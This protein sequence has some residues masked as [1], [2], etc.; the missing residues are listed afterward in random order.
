MDASD[1]QVNRDAA[2]VY[3]EFFVPAL[4]APWAPK[5]ADALKPISNGFMLDVACGTGVLGRELARRVGPARVSGVDC[6]EGMLAVARRM[7]PDVGWRVARAEALPFES[8]QCAG[9]GSQFGL[10]FFEDRARAL[11]E[12]WRVLS[13]GGGLAVAV[14]GALGDTPGY[15]AMAALLASLFGEPIADELRAPF[16]LGDPSMLRELFE[17][18]GIPGFELET[19]IGTARFP[20]IDAWVCT[21][22]RGW[23][24]ADRI[25]DQQFSL[26][27]DEA[28]RA[29]SRFVLADGSVEFASPAHIVSARKR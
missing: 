20:S 9:V 5:V 27:R 8:G 15:D 22:V 10:M 26:L 2:S 24:L 14:W 16:C 11:S 23:T 7:A 17:D 18:S 21:D 6:N 28:P 1:G 12:M 25:D 4:F 13:P 29:L 3:E 19:A